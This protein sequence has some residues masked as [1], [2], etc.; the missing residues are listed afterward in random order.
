[1]VA[2]ESRAS[3]WLPSGAKSD[4]Q[5]PGQGGGACDPWAKDAGAGTGAGTRAGVGPGDGFGAGASRRLQGWGAAA[6][7]P[8]PLPPAGMGEATATA[9]AATTAAA[10]NATSGESLAI[11]QESCVVCMD[12][13]KDS[14]L[15]HGDS[16]HQCC[17]LEC[18][19]DLVAR[20]DLCPICR[21]PIES[22]LRLFLT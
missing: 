5:A 17:C 18:A 19:R 15:V 9:V 10:A 8:P 21:E 11:D 1:V 20:K 14:V 3:V 2:A 7:S 22:T 6:S 13:P 12:G 4:H 16:A